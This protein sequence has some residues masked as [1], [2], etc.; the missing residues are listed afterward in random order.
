MMMRGGKGNPRIAIF[1]FVATF[2]LGL[3]PAAA[4]SG[5]GIPRPA[6]GD[7]PEVPQETFVPTPAGISVTPYVTGLEV[8]WSLA[9]APDG[10][11]FIAERPGRI[12]VASADGALDPEPWL[13]LP[14]V[15]RLEDGLLGMAL[16]PDFADQ[17]YV[18]VYYT[19]AK[20]DTVNRVSRFREV[21]G[22]GVE[23][24]ILL[25]DIPS[26]R[27]HNGGRLRFGPDGMLYISTGDTSEPMRSQDRGDLAGSIL[28]LA[29]DGTIPADNPWPGS[30]IWAYGIRSTHGLA[31]RPADGALFAA[32]NG[33]SGEWRNPT[34]GARDEVNIIRRGGNYGWPRAVGAPG[35]ADFVDPIV[36]WMPAAAPGDLI[37]YDQTLMPDL[38]GDLFYSSLSAQALIRIR[39]EDEAEP[40][41]VTAIERWFH[42][43]EQGGS[44][45][46]RLRGMAVG[47]DGALYIGTGNLDG[48]APRREG[49]DRVLRIAPN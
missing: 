15:S 26:A 12:R 38:R 40:N 22:R 13:I 42:T 20:G 7:L 31:F 11:L 18:Y 43:G 14:A 1:A 48:R 28:R 35:L 37:F 4:Q 3:G 45:Y 29:P 17:P 47:P 10:R 2:G 41:R 33:P 23:E 5:E 9:F 30:P 25:D 16:H 21:D 24:E 44:S 39:L 46:G 19:V 6:V 8:I 32:D 49:D 36:S 27:I 34:I